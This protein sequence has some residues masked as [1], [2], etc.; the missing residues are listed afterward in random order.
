MD[1][2]NA[3]RAAKTVSPEETAMF[4]QQVA[5]VLKSGIPM[6]DGIEA[7]C[8]NYRDTRYGA[9]FDRLSQMVKDTGSLYEAIRDLG[10]FPAYMVQMTKIG[11][12]TGSLDNVMDALGDY[13]ERE[14]GVRKSV[15]N[16]VVYPLMLIVMMAAVIILLIA[17]VLP[18]FNQVFRSLGMELSASASA[19]MALGMGAGQAVLWLVGALLVISL[20]LFLLMKTKARPQ[21]LQMLNRLFPQVKKIS[22][23]LAAERFASVMAAM[24]RSGYPLEEAVSLIP[25]LLNDQASR[26]KVL[27]CKKAMAEGSSFPDAVEG[28]GLFEPLHLKM[29]RV[30]F[31][32]G[33]VDQVMEKLAAMYQE[34]ID[35]RISRL[36]S[37]IEPTMVAVLSIVIGAIL[38]AVML[39]LASILSAII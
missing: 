12:K 5:M 34:D 26:E 20:A 3:Q 19:V 31:T 13:Y 39:P 23:R 6:Y 24:M 14:T 37:L 33:Q 11:E 18:V 32:T 9:S 7:M 4:C 25:G 30:G 1:Q 17:T 27:Q 2:K 28:A 38:L 36:V 22:Q 10:I 21:A 35:N 8:E 16:A 15:R 29:I